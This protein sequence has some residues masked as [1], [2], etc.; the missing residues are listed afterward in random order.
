M[1]GNAHKSAVHSPVERLRSPS[2]TFAGKE[3]SVATKEEL[4][5]GLHLLVAEA[6]RIGARLTDE[7]WGMA[8]DEAGWN[9]RQMF[10][11]VAAVGTIVVP[12]MTAIANAPAGA[13]SGAGLDID[14]MNAQT[15]AQRAD[16]SIGDLVSE[17]QSGYG[18]VV[19]F[20]DKT[21][22]EFFERRGTVGGYKDM[23]IGD[24]MMQMIVMHGVSHLYHAAS[25]FP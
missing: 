17:Y 14:A 21:P 23:T 7:E 19:D 13:D 6:K 10:A 22:A 18:S 12:F 3:D 2:L 15:V 11:H 24:L 8:S 1:R 5:S 25:R 9:N 20:V 16:R 4:T